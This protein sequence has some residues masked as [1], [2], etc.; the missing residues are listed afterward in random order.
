MKRQGQTSDLTDQAQYFF[1]DFRS[2]QALLPRIRFKFM[3][4]PF[5]QMWK[6][7]KT[8]ELIYSTD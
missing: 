7:V 6:T 3:F 4:F 1:L 2:P 8:K 5:L